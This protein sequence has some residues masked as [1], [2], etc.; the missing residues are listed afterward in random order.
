LYRINPH[1]ARVDYSSPRS[2]FLSDCHLKGDRHFSDVVRFVGDSH[3]ADVARSVGDSHF[4]DVV[5]FSGDG[6]QN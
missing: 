1:D 3:F 5:R 4:S 2:N 6:H